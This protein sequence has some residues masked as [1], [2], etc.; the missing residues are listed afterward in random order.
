MVPV[1]LRGLHAKV[2]QLERVRE[3]FARLQAPLRWLLAA[4][5]D[6]ESVVRCRSISGSLALVCPSHPYFA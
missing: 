5:E 3:A 2:K 6:S 1:K 4:T